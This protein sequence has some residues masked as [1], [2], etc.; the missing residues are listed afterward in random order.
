MRN[1]SKVGH[2]LEYREA[3]T[4]AERVTYHG[5]YVFSAVTDE[6]QMRTVNETSE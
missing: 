5:D 2:R 6:Q 3:V 1:R 4:W